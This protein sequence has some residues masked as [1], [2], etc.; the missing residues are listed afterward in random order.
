MRR[1]YTIASAGLIDT[2]GGIY[3]PLTTPTVFDVDTV[4]N[5]VRRGIEVY[6]HN[7]SNPTEKIR[8]TT[9]NVNTIVFKTTRADAVIRR[10][11]NMSVREKGEDRT[12]DTTNVERKNQ[13]Q[14]NNDKKNIKNNKENVTIEINKD[15]NQKDNKE[16]ISKPD[17]FSKN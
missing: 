6:Q 5:M 16:E 7:P 17:D 10:N 8:V 11:L 12:P 2:A 3:G 1:L 4:V 15:Q 9:K 13:Q 14:N